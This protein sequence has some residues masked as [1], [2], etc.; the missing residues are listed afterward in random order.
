MNTQELNKLSTPFVQFLLLSFRVFVILTIC[1][2]VSSCIF[3]QNIAPTSDLSR[4]NVT[5]VANAS[6]HVVKRGETLFAIAWKYGL[7]YRQLAIANNIDRRFLIYPGQVLSLST[8]VSPVI[9][10][11]SASNVKKG[12]VISPPVAPTTSSTPLP[13]QSVSRKVVKKP[14]EAPSVTARAEKKSSSSKRVTVSNSGS[15]KLYWRWP[16]KGKVITNFSSAKAGNKGIDLAGKKGDS[17]TAAASGTIVYAGS[18]LRGYGKLIIIK[19]NET[20]LSAYAHNDRIRV[21][22]GQKVKLGQHIADI[23]SSGSRANINKL[24]FEIRR[25][26]QS[27]NPIKYLPKRKS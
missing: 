17:V 27:V 9:D 12:K 7:D 19:H 15:Q 26:G 3:S 4:K 16:A 11:S 13:K 21:R 14:T 6:E 2:V 5:A 10:S 23:G 18:G 24:H 25:N 22:E 8:K 1:I 20:Y